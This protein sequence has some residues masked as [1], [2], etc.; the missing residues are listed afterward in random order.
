MLSSSGPFTLMKLMP[1]SLATA[2]ANSVL[3]QPG[4]PQRRMP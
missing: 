2:L 3:P 1:V 4:G